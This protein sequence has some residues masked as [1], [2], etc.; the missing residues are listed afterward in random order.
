MQVTFTD[1]PVAHAQVCAPGDL[2]HIDD[3]EEPIPRRSQA[4]VIPSQTLNLNVAAFH[5]ETARSLNLLDDYAGPKEFACS[6]DSRTHRITFHWTW[7]VDCENK[8]RHNLGSIS[9]L[10]ARKNQ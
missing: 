7:Y 10:A 5:R 4:L 3:T 8:I 6:S 2:G 9:C 1:D